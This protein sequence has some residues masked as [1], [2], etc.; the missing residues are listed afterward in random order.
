[1]CVKVDKEALRSIIVLKS[2][3]MSTSSKFPVS[4]T[5]IRLSALD[6]AFVKQSAKQFWVG[7]WAR[8]WILPEQASFR[9]I[10]IMWIVSFCSGRW[11][12]L[13]VVTKFFASVLMW[14]FVTSPYRSIHNPRRKWHE[15]KHFMKE[16][17]STTV[18]WSL[19]RFCQEYCLASFWR[20]IIVVSVRSIRK[21]QYSWWSNEWPLS[22][23]HLLWLDLSRQFVKRRNIANCWRSCHRSTS[24]EFVTALE[25]CPKPIHLSQ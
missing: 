14:I 24:G 25:L 4:T 5:V 6:E 2:R 16:Y 11:I 7:M 9:N 1:M 10:E 3:W 20:A 8:S 17:N 23:I 15:P 21:S 12:V 13:A 18:L 22:K 19:T